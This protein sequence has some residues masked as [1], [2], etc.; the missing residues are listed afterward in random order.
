MRSLQNTTLQGFNIPFNT[1]NG[2]YDIY[3]RPKQTIQVPDDYSS[4]VMNNLI[5]RRMLK[6]TKIETKYK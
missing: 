1:P 2:L 3:L 6:I 4:K 5:L